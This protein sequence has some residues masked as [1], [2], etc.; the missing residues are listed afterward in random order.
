ML[1]LVG[2]DHIRIG[3]GRKGKTAFS[4]IEWKIWGT[5]YYFLYHF[6]PHPHFFLFLS[7]NLSFCTQIPRAGSH[8][9]W[10][11]PGRFWRRC[12]HGC[13]LGFV[14]VLM[15]GFSLSLQVLLLMCKRQGA[16][17]PAAL[18]PVDSQVPGFAGAFI[19]NCCIGNSVEKVS[20]CVTD[21]TGIAQVLLL[22]TWMMWYLIGVYSQFASC[23]KSASLV[24]S[25]EAVPP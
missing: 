12:Q 3:R 20:L 24:W 9:R 18:A 14:L 11:K 22:L 15:W 16:N 13:L 17:I 4:L 6:S 23:S 5:G 1:S 10:K 8:V 2:T 19:H 25:R 21:W 7:Y